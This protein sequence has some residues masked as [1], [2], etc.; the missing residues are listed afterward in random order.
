MT[1]KFKI[2]HKINQDFTD[3]IPHQGTVE[4]KQIKGVGQITSQNPL[5]SYIL[6]IINVDGK[7]IHIMCDLH[8]QETLPEKDDGFIEMRY[9]GKCYLENDII[10][11]F[12]AT[13]S[14]G[15]YPNTDAKLVVGTDDENCEFLEMS[16]YFLKLVDQIK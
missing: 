1:S 3:W 6:F 7:T 2:T 13:V 16:L 14:F 5:E 9:K 11:Q 8:T 15:D 10:N 12:K 4:L